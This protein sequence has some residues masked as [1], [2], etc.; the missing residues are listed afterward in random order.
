METLETR[1]AAH[2]TTQDLLDR[3]DAALSEMGVDTASVD[4]LKPVDE[5]HTG[6]LESTD[7]LL[8]QLEI[9]PETKVLDIGC[10]LGG[11]ARHVVHRYGAHVTGVDLT[12]LF[13]EVG[14]ALNARV[15]LDE[16]IDLHVGSAT[17]LPMDDASFDLVSMFHVGMNIA[18][19]E[20]LFA[21]VARVLKPGGRFALFDVMRDDNA[22]DLQFPLPWS[23]KPE[24]SFVDPA[25][26]YADAAEAVGLALHGQRYRRDFTLSYFA[27]VFEAIE[28]AGGPPPLGIHLLM[29]DTAGEKLKNY[30]A[31]VEA[32]RIAPVEMIFDK[33]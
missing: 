13:V 31:N 4:D 28:K 19:K 18:D 23:E 15:H 17:D 14:R 1:V 25:T 7:A 6:G 33:P 26:V 11:T 21:E 24:S 27:H 29:G 8:S 32:H 20:H 22:E 12:P 9:T 3:I 2:Y 5:F 30:V 16:A 10:G